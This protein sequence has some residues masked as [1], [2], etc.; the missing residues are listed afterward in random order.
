M[1]THRR[2]LILGLM[3]FLLTL[4]ACG[5]DATVLPAD[6][7]GDDSGVVADPIVNYHYI[8]KHPDIEFTIEPVIPLEISEGPNPG[9]HTVWG[10]NIINVSFRMDADRPDNRCSIHCN[11]DLNFTAEGEITLDE[12]TGKCI[13]PMRFTFT[14]EVDRWILESNCPQELQAVL[15]CANLSKGLADPS[16]YTFEANKRDVTLPTEKEVTLRA[17]LKNFNMPSELE[18]ICD[19]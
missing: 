17:E 8:V 11:G 3:I 9:S 1:S 6:P 14:P 5:P 7:V 19:W 15:D 12:K 2:V 18:G 16:I 13:I 4:S 10:L